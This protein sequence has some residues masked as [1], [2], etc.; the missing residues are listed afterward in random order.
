ME[1][2]A[3]FPGSFDPITLGHESIVKRALHVFD[4]IIVG[5]GHNSAKNYMF[6]IDQRKAWVDETFAN[7][8]RVT[9]DVY[10]G[11]TVSFCKQVGA[12]FILR[13]IRNTNDFEF[14]RTIASM[15][16]AMAPDIE[17][18]SV[19]PEPHVHAINSTVVRDILKHGGDVSAFVP[20]AIHIPAAR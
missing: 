9:C 15:N 4:R 6:D 1:R 16:H 20:S 14:E 13:G 12:R 17:T 11:L 8:S 3:V 2:I 18:V 19:F 5:I 10:E 7:E